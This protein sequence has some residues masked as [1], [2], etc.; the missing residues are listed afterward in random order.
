MLFGNSVCVGLTWS[1]VNR[2]PL[3]NSQLMEQVNN[4]G[5]V[6]NPLWLGLGNTHG[7]ILETIQVIFIGLRSSKDYY[8]QPGGGVGILEWSLGCPAVKGTR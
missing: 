3:L 1:T 7:F 5:M 2:L 6:V 8:K 4:V